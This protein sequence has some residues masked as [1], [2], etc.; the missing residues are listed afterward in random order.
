MNYF[1][2]KS[3]T[4]KYY[5]NQDGNQCI[6]LLRQS[7]LLILCWVVSVVASAGHSAVAS[8]DY[9]V[10]ILNL[11]I[12]SLQ[13]Q[14]TKNNRLREKPEIDRANTLMRQQRFVE[15]ASQWREI[16]NKAKAI[17]SSDKDHGIFAVLALLGNGYA[18][19]FA[20]NI[21]VAENAL[22][23]A[24]KQMQRF[25]SGHELS[26]A[27]AY[28]L[29][30]N[31]DVVHYRFDSA[32]KNYQLTQQWLSARSTDLDRAKQQALFSGISLAKGEALYYLENYIEAR[33]EF[34]KALSWSIQF[35]DVDLELAA[36]TARLALLLRTA[37]A[38]GS[39]Q[40]SQL[41]QD[42]F[43]VDRLPQLIEYARPQTF[44]LYADVF[45]QIPARYWQ[46]ID[47]DVLQVSQGLQSI[48]TSVSDLSLLKASALG[49]LSRFYSVTGKQQGAEELLQRAVRVAQQYGDKLQLSRWLS[50]F[51]AIK[52]QQGNYGA[53]LKA[54]RMAV[55]HLDAIKSDV[56]V[57]NKYSLYHP[58]DY[59]NDIYL[60]LA[61]LL[62]R[63]SAQVGMHQKQQS[64]LREARQILETKK[65]LDLQ[66]YFH[67]QC[68]AN[69]KKNVRTLD[70]L[71][72]PD[73][74]VFY[75]IVL[76]DRLELLLSHNGELTRF[77]SPVSRAD[78]RSVVNEFRHQ[79]VDVNTQTYLANARQLYDWLIRPMQDSLNADKIK[80]LVIVS[81][82]LL[83]TVPFSVFNDGENFLVQ[84]YA[85][86]LSP[87]LSLTDPE[88]IK[89]GN[90]QV[91]LG[92]LSES[93]QGFPALNY[94]KGELEEIQDLY[95]NELLLNRDF[96]TR[97]FSEALSNPQ[98]SIAHVASHSEMSFDSRR[99][100]ILTF[101]GKISFDQLESMTS[102]H[103]R[104]HPIELLTLSACQTAAG[105]DRAAL[106]LAGVA[107]KSGARSALATLW[108]IDDLASSLL[109]SEF[110]RQLSDSEIS[111]AQAL[112]N[113]QKTLIASH[114]FGHPAYWSSF[115]LIGNWL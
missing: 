96:V 79:L 50:E 3:I 22:N 102:I 78:L 108:A 23:L 86:A 11:S 19:F 1:A 65:N 71:A 87:A 17:D 85:L 106:G 39:L 30:A 115:L 9:G 21:D 38:N 20:G 25:D 92:G 59:F 8:S 109:V 69:F 62:L 43:P 45:S 57:D 93:V 83:R 55:A 104:R 48:I 16:Y 89:R 46:Q 81:E 24:F 42:L 101:D 61:D 73:T 47:K 10:Q 90:M 52:N 53:G 107:V 58:N 82:S 35:K 70:E 67:D 72:I 4:P 44:L 12:Q 114:R 97:R 105:D 76:P 64:M 7:L 112:R 111:K 60:G 27:C 103:K 51:G 68:I 84:K 100:Y 94:V 54:F 95:A 91:L 13:P 99:S 63:Q 37:D 98:F 77:V 40:V 33:Q 88:K 75:P 41:K 113:A 66:N 15:A 14:N 29:S 74:A 26:L 18:Q 49:I 32:L 34:D 5:K 31:I 2:F 28:Y 56:M 110:Y 80:N 36:I 6:E